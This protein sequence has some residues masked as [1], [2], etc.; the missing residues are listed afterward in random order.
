MALL[1]LGNAGETASLRL[2][3]TTSTDDSGLLEWLLPDFEQASGIRVEVIAVGTGKAL[4]LGENGDADVVLVH[5]REAEEAFVAAGHGRDRR[6]V[7]KNDFLLVGPGHDP[8]GLSQA[9]GLEDALRRLKGCQAAFISRG[10]DSGTNQRERQLWRLVGGPPPATCLLE[11]GQGMA[12][13][14]RMADE[15]RG[16][17]LSDRG[18]FLALGASLGLAP[19]FQGDARLENVY[20]VIAV[21]P[22]RIG[23]ERYRQARGFVEWITSP[24]AQA[25]IGAFRVAGQVLF[26]P[27]AVSSRPPD[28]CSAQRSWRSSGSR[29]GFP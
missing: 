5:A 19:L 23:Q 2:A 13:T 10:D 20:G 18:T 25:R 9:D 15:K 8:A 27:T 26:H 7:M 21:N 17:T 3:T 12:A 14:L 22:Q 28:C 6:E 29:C 24:A 16:Y 4:K 11:V 1:S